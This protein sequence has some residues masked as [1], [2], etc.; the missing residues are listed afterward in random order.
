MGPEGWTL[1]I[2][3]TRLMLAWRLVPVMVAES[4]GTLTPLL[5]I[6]NSRIAKRS[7]SG[8][9]ADTGTALKSGAE[10]DIKMHTWMLQKARKIE[11]ARSSHE[12]IARPICHAA[13]VNN[14]MAIMLVSEARCEPA[15]PLV[16][17]G[18]VYGWGTPVS[19]RG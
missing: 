17:L 1:I 4:N 8:T 2:K 5:L 13:W 18:G 7:P 11:A 16:L 3:R 12:L 15:K 10:V 19:P 9:G 14:Q 6:T